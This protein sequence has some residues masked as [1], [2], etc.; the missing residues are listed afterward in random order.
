MLPLLGYLSLRRLPNMRVFLS[1]AFVILFAFLVLNAVFFQSLLFAQ[2]AGTRK[3]G[4]QTLCINS[5]PF[6][7]CEPLATTLPSVDIMANNFGYGFRQA[8][9]ACGAQRC[10]LLFACQCGPPLGVGLCYDGGEGGNCSGIRFTLPKLPAFGVV[11]DA[12]L[13]STRIQS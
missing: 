2:P 10:Y 9:T 6:D 3:C 8:T 13:T 11:P 1:N 12:A 4:Q 7:I 5:N